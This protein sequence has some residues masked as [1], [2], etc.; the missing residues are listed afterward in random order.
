MFVVNGI[1][2]YRKLSH[3]DDRNTISEDNDP[4][5]QYIFA[6]E[7]EDDK[8]GDN[9]MQHEIRDGDIVKGFYSFID[10]DGSRRTVEYT[11]DP[12]KGFN[13]IIHREPVPVKNKNV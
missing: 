5:P 2:T 10:A 1:T 4:H 6:Y 8:T 11:A 9:K 13:A 3:S 12:H 7:I